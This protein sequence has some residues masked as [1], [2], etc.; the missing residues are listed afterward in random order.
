MPQTTDKYSKLTLIIDQGSHASRIALFSSK[1]ELVYLKSTKITANMPQQSST[2]TICEQ[3]ASEILQSIEGLLNDIPNELIHTIKCCGICTQRSS[4][5][6]WHKTSG[7]PLSPLISWQDTR[8]KAMVNKLAD[9]AS[10]IRKITGLPF[11]AHYSATKI[12]WLLENNNAVKQAAQNKQLRI[13]PLASFL[14]FNLLNEKPHLIDHS[15]A[16]RCQLFDIHR[17]NWSNELLA[18]FEID[19]STLPDCTPVI[20][21]FGTLRLNN[22]PVTSV[23]GDQNAVLY[24]YAKLQKD[25]ALINIGTG[26]FILSATAERQSLKP[27]LLQTITSSYADE[28]SYITEGTVNGAG[29]T[30]N[31]AQS[32]SPCENLYHKLPIW[33][34]KIHSPPIFVN[35]VSGIGS[36]WWCNAGKPELVGENIVYDGRFYVAIIESIIFLIFKN[37]QQLA[38]PPENIF[39][40]GGLSQLDGI[41]QKLADLSR[42]NVVRYSEAEASARGCAWLANQLTENENKHWENLQISR[43]FTATSKHTADDSLLERYQQFVG[44]LNARCNYD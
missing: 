38:T 18:L 17:L 3:D 2:Q 41:C 30:L 22:I 34:K 44:E 39:I 28:A 43:Q 1:G 10:N 35:S 6:A 24:A 33:L 42:I 19:R 23:C 21:H 8:G 25:E 32:L 11:S 31:W 7:K 5:V 36:P 20:H 14:L 26:A 29:A 13:S 27:R 9:H 16:Q 4:I 12:H 15:N 37:I 40:S